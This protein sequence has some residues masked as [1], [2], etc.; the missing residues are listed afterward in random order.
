M[1]AL[2]QDYHTQSDFCKM[3]DYQNKLF[4]RTGWHLSLAKR[5][6][7]AGAFISAMMKLMKNAKWNHNEWEFN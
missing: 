7:Y 1:Q 4:L 3:E 6:L 2:N 5:L